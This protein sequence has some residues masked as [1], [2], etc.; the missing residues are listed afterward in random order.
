MEVSTEEVFAVLDKL[1]ENLGLQLEEYDFVFLT[2]AELYVEMF[3]LMFPT[4]IPMLNIDFSQ[5][6]VDDEELLQSLLDFLSQYII[7]VDLDHI[8]SSLITQGDPKHILNFL[9]LIYEISKMVIAKEGEEEEGEEEAQ[10]EPSGKVVVGEKLIKSSPNSF[11]QLSEHSQRS[12]DGEWQAAKYHTAQGIPEEFID[13]IAEEED[14]EAEQAAHQQAEYDAHHA[15]AKQGREYRKDNA[16]QQEGYDNPYRPRTDSQRESYSGSRISEVSKSKEFSDYE[17]NTKKKSG[18]GRRSEEPTSEDFERLRNYDALKRNQQQQQQEEEVEDQEEEEGEGEGDEVEIEEEEE[19]E[20]LQDMPEDES[21]RYVSIRERSH[22]NQKI[23]SHLEGDEIEPGQEGEDEDEEGEYEYV[24][25]DE[26]GN[27]HPYVPGQEEEDAEYYASD[28]IDYNSIKAKGQ[29][30]NEQ[31]I[32]E[33]N[34]EEQEPEEDQ[35]EGEEEGEEGQEYQYQYGHE[36]PQSGVD[37]SHAE[38]E[39]HQLEPNYAQEHEM[40]AQNYYYEQQPK[41]ATKKAKGTK[42]VKKARPQT[43]KA[44]TRPVTAQTYKKPEVQYRPL[45]PV[46]GNYVPAP[47]QTKKESATKKKVTQ[48]TAKKS[49]KKSFVQ[50]DQSDNQSERSNTENMRPKYGNQNLSRNSQNNSRR[51]SRDEEQ[52]K[53]ARNSNVSNRNPMG[54]SYPKL[55]KPVKLVK[56]IRIKGDTLTSAFESQQSM[57]YDRIRDEKLDYLKKIHKIIFQLDKKRVLEERKAYMD[58]RR[59]ID[60]DTIGMMLTLKHNYK[61][62]ID[63]LKRG[64]LNDRN[65]RKMSDLTQKMFLH[66][67]K[68]EL[69]LDQ[70]KEID[71]LRNRW[72]NEKLRFEMMTQDENF[73]EKRLVDLYKK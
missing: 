34:E 33:H 31:V 51:I 65:E 50:R 23:A 37:E 47:V 70:M 12:S 2:Q 58:Y 64:H 20:E 36:E 67:L 40:E 18:I 9:Q 66:T 55:R 73:L 8:S 49:I 38:S 5:D 54:I 43:A 52:Q 17:L 60:E 59:S 48:S 62:K 24:Y 61:E 21:D 45:R 63:G 14:Q 1:L 44:Q 15:A 22:H 69:S 27:L 10:S 53:Y 35:E 56:P 42:K 25:E 72:S 68:Q 29:A 7:K 19:E 28:P 3:K 41:M 26:Y 57:L 4:L 71:R 6:D 11:K 39:D 32:V 30:K 46:T 16:R 13:M